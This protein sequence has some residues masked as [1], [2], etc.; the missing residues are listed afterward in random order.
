[1]TQVYARNV[2][3]YDCSSDCSLLKKL[4]DNFPSDYIVY[5]QQLGITWFL[6]TP[7]S[8]SLL[9]FPVIFGVCVIVWDEI[10]SQSSFY[11]QFPFMGK[12]VEHFFFT[13]SLGTFTSFEN[14]LFNSFTSSYWSIW[15]LVNLMFFVC[16]GLFL[17]QSQAQ[18]DITLFM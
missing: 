7:I 5:P 15:D 14:Y 1:M 9:A 2:E 3:L 4:H 6:F 16:F 8:T 18:A 12:M 13:Y 11:L 17:R 10:S